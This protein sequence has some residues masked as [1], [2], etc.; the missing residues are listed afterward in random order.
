MGRLIESGW[1][2]GINSDLDDEAVKKVA[3]SLRLWEKEEKSLKPSVVEYESRT[4]KL[5]Q[6]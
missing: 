4:H 3:E 2:E 5:K 1:S 6:V